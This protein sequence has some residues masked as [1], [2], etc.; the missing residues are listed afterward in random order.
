MNAPTPLGVPEQA[1]EED[2]KIRNRLRRPQGQVTPE[3]T[4]VE[5]GGERLFTRFFGVR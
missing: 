4:S 1:T 5:S 2:R 3:L